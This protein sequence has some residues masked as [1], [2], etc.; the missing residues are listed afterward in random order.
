M[1]MYVSEKLA[2]RIVGTTET[3][4]LAREAAGRAILDV[5]AAAVAS[6]TTP[7]AVA[8]RN[9]ALAAWGAGDIPIWFASKRSTRLGATFANS[10]A[11]SILDLDDGHRAAAGHPGA[12]IIPAVLAA[13]HENPNLAT[14]ALDAIAI[15]YEVG[16]RI[17]ASRDLRTLDT[18]DSGRW[19]GQAA[20]AAIGW[21]HR[22]S[23]AIIADAIAAAGTVAPMI[24]T[25]NFTQVGNHIKEA[26]PH[27]TINGLTSL[28]LAEAGFNAP[29]DILNDIRYFD[30]ET[31]LDGWGETWCVETAYFKP[32]SCCRYLHAPI[33]GLLKIMRDKG[34]S[35]REISR[36]RVETFHRALSLPNQVEPRSLQHAQY[37]I[38]FCLGVAAVRGSGALLPMTDADLLIDPTILAVSSLVELVPDDELDRYFSAAVPSRIT[39]S[40]GETHL[41]ETVMAPLGEPTNPMGWDD[42]FNKFHHLA[43]MQL[44]TSHESDLRKALNKVRE[45]DITLLLTELARPA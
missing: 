4:P 14:K 3:S 24:A 2:E 29:L 18:V 33:D 41:T 23:P 20:A 9:G 43:S 36:I 42:L 12:S 19:C 45:G 22:L 7:G 11:S 25:A 10:T 26:I 27:A 39:V 13:V 1:N 8:A 44:S 38:P 21:L 34:L 28:H 6:Q 32:Y 37:S 17:A 16:I 5:V 30:G 35:F 31:L 40:C 15:G